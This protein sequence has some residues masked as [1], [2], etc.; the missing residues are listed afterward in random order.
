MNESDACVLLLLRFAPSSRIVHGFFL[1][2]SPGGMWPE[3]RGGLCAYFLLAELGYNLP[4]NISVWLE[5]AWSTCF[6]DDFENRRD[7]IFV[8]TSKKR[9]EKKKWKEKMPVLWHWKAKGKEKDAI[10]KG[11]I[12]LRAHCNSFQAT[13]LAPPPRNLNAWV[14]NALFSNSN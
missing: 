8:T 3:N 4:D 6:A 10:V 12:Y 9:G 11:E 2:C 7:T 14:A 13:D 5:V 1:K